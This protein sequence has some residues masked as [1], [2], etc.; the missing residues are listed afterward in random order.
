MKL[1]TRLILVLSEFREFILIKQH[2]F[3][4]HLSRITNTEYIFY[5]IEEVDCQWLYVIQMSG[6]ENLIFP[7][8]G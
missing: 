3:H 4:F 7:L 1:L 5:Y 8:M 6:N 2:C